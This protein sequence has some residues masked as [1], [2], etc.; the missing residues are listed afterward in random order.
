MK[1]GMKLVLIISSINLVG[2]GLLAGITLSLSQ[3]EISRLAEEEAQS[4]A[5]ESSE[6]IRNWINEYIDMART[7]AYAMQ[8]YKEIPADQRRDYFNWMMKWVVLSKPEENSFSVYANWSSDGLDGMDAQFANTPGT[9]ETG[10]YVPLW[11]LINGNPV[12]SPIPGFGWPLIMQVLKDDKEYMLDPA[13]NPSN[14]GMR[15]VANMGVAVR[16][17]DTSVTIGVVGTAFDVSMLQTMVSKVK[18]FGDGNAFL[19]SSGG[20]IAAH[21]DAERLGKNMKET[22]TDTFGPFID[23]M[24]KAVSTGTAASFSYRP[25]QSDTVIQYYAVPFTVGRSPNPWTLVVSV[26]RNTVM[27]PIYS[28][29]R[30]CLIIGVLIMVFMSAGIILTAR[31]ISRP[32]TSTMT[33]LKDI[34]EG[35]LTKEIALHSHDELGDLA[36]YLNFTVDRI[37]GLVLS[38][39]KEAQILSQTGSDLASN[40]TETAASI[41]EITANIQSIKAQTS[42]Q[43]ASIKSTSSIME[44]VVENIESLNGQIQKQTDC[45][46]QSSSAVEQMLANIQSVTET[47]VKNESNVT[48]LSQASEVGRSSLQEVSMDIQEIDRESA[49]L[50]EINAVMEN[51]ASQ[52]NLL[53]MN[54]AIEA[55]HA[56]EAGKGF[57][58][59]A[60]EIRKLAESSSE[61]SKTISDVLKKI[62]SSVDKITSSTGAVLRNFEAISDGVK[63]VTDQEAN[64]RSAM[65][66]Q[67]IGSKAILE[68][69]K[70]LKEITGEVKGSAQGMRGGSHEVI[71][72][73]KTLEGITA[74]IGDGMQ[75]MASGAEQIDRAVN[76]VNDISLEN[77]KQI[78]LLMNE[79]AR[80]K[81]E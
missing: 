68:S 1:I 56:G 8:G 67:G 57:A 77:K 20:I 51:I 44:Q 17:P 73:S 18:P 54:A 22:E 6:E 47:L 62:K 60:D 27:A 34:A 63:T 2:I 76:R 43:T 53:S 39:R 31:S 21:P 42:R 29:L 15:L 70:R 35:Y 13:V 25:A 4:I 3:R 45:V 41:S 74:E 5:R 24:I 7:L 58:V 72:E 12:L 32:I 66:E 78:E 38:I 16:D 55:A 69:I 23:T 46:S 49:G 14:L 37:K 50:L 81:V 71:Q 52:T 59:V 11:N 19:F 33:V 9:D 61:Q 80:F 48:K 36:R 64:V 26:S 40:M 30:I 65:E 28:M 79:V 75:E 10:R